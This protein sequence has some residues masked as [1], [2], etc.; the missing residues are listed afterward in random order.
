MRNTLLTSAVLNRK[1]ITVDLQAGAAVATILVLGAATGG[2]L[3]RYRT[4]R[5]EHGTHVVVEISFGLVT[6]G[7]N[8]VDAVMVKV[9]NLSGHPIRVDS[10]AVEVNDGSNRIGLI[11]GAKPGFN[12][13]GVVAPHDS[14][15]TWFES[16]DLVTHGLDLYRP[17]RARVSLADHQ[18]FLWSERKAL[19]RR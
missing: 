9:R 11:L 14:G 1:R 8:A 3:W 12:I 13:P 4:W 19:M 18:G 17:A 2:G 15:T 10:V 7:P 6:L 16:T 5:Q